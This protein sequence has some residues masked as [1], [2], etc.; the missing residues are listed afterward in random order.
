MQTKEE[1]FL[2][3]ALLASFI[4]AF[5]LLV[6]TIIMFLMDRIPFL[7]IIPS[8]IIFIIISFAVIG[9]YFTKKN[10]PTHPLLSAKV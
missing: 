1:R 7:S 8:I 4:L 9:I 10:N 2:V 3:G 5:A 6:F